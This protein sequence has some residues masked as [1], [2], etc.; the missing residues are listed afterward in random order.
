MLDR[1]LNTPV[2]T[3]ELATDFDGRK[4]SKFCITVIF[5]KMLEKSCKFTREVVLPSNMFILSSM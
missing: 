3:F 4:K 5:L 2:G 1:V